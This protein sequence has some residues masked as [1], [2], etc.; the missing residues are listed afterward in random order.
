MRLCRKKF[1]PRIYADDADKNEL[2]S[3]DPRHP[4][5]SAAKLRLLPSAFCLLL[6]SETR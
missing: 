6:S 1:L 5:K 4:R 2:I 3:S